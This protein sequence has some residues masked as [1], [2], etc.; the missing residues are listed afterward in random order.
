MSSELFLAVFSKPTPLTVPYSPSYRIEHATCVHQTLIEAH[1]GTRRGTTEVEHAEPQM[2]TWRI[3]ATR[4]LLRHTEATALLLR[5]QSKYL[6]NNGPASPNC[7][8][9]VVW[10]I[11]FFDR[12]FYPQS[13]LPW[14]SAEFPLVR[15]CT[16]DDWSP[17]P[18]YLLRRA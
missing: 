7:S 14:L 15:E 2:M 4:P 12:F 18:I 6:S 10:D 9:L 5:I 8:I 3:V 13:Q 11:L 1:T 17:P 16:S